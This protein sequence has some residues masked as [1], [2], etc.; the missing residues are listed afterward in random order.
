MGPDKMHARI[1]RKPM[2]EAA[3]ILSII[4]K[5]SWQS[6]QVPNDLKRGNI[7]PIFKNSKKKDPGD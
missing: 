2:D 5:K 3:K 1:P 4:Y 7:I 6:G